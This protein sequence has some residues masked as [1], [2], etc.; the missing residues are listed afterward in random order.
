MDHHYHEEIQE[1]NGRQYR[2]RFFYDNDHEAP[3]EDGDGRGIVHAVSDHA[4]KKPGWRLLYTNRGDA[5]YLEW[6]GTIKKAKDEGWGLGDEKLAQLRA[7]LG[8]DPTPGQIRERAVQMEYD[9]FRAWAMR[10]IADQKGEAVEP[11]KDKEYTDWA[12]LILALDTWVAG[13]SPRV[14]ACAGS[15]G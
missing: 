6:A 7:T 14:K 8:A 2:V 12:A 3:W 1:H 13:L 10:R 4:D 9:F 5:W 15:R 11:G